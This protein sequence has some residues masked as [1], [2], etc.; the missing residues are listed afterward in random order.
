MFKFKETIKSPHI[1]ISL[2][3]GISIIVLAYFSKRIL[4][5]PIGYLPL[6]IPPF[7]MTIWEALL[8]KNKYEKICKTWYWIV[9][10][11]IATVLVIVFHAV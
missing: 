7:L 10:I 9:A 5:E 1:H 8:S 6:A 2:A 11:F 4:P 3:T